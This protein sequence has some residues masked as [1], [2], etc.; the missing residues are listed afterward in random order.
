VVLSKGLHILPDTLRIPSGITLAGQGIETVVMLGPERRGP[1]L[2]NADDDLHDVVLRDFV[3]EG[4]IS[5]EVPDD[6][7]SDRRKRSYQNAPSRS[8]IVFSALREGQMRNIRLEHVTVRNCTHD[9]VAIRGATDVAI[10]AC[11]VSD[12]GSSVVP[13]PGLQHN[14]LITRSIKCEVRN[15]RLDTSPWGSGVFVSHCRDVL[16]SNNE[17]ARNA[18]NGVRATESEKIRILGNLVEGNDGSGIL[19]NAMMDGCRQVDVRENVSR[20]NGGYGLEIRRVVDS[21]VQNNRLVDNGYANQMVVDASEG[22]K[23]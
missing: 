18:L 15:S 9:G 16:I 5:S 4:A 7:N 19:L 12:N 14:L 17:M 20:N 2:V 3:V 10:V 21:A 13:G 23:Q 1:A 22:I 11:D 8:G 6:P